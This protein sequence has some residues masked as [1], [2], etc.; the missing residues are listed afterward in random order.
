MKISLLVSTSTVVLSLSAAARADLLPADGLKRV[1]YS[2]TPHLPADTGN[3]ALFAYPWSG[4]TGA[5]KMRATPLTDTRSLNVG[6]HEGCQI[7]VAAKADVDSFTKA[8]GAAVPEAT[9]AL[10]AKAKACTGG[11]TPVHTVASTDSRK[12]INEDVDVKIDKGGCTVTARVA[13]AVNAVPAPSTNTKGAVDAA[14]SSA[15]DAPSSPSSAAPAA[16]TPAAEKKGGCN[17]TGSAP[18]PLAL[19]LALPAMFMM[20]TK[21]KPA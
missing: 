9:K 17:E 11:P 20:R 10:V 1:S 12:S 2:F 3:Q 8:T 21:R 5:P 19:L 16:T 6:T 7:Y 14:A 4:S 15:G 18:S 13:A